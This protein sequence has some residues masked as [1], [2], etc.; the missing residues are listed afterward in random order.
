M[1]KI[2]KILVAKD[3]EDYIN[4]VAGTVASLIA[5]VI[6]IFFVRVA[7]MLIT[8]PQHTLFPLAQ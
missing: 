5:T 8:I 7:W 3:T 4:I 1:K 6:I 2:L